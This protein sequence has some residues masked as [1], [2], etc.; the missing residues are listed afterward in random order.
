MNE[1]QVFLAV[2]GT[3]EVIR[4][5][6]I[7]GHA[8]YLVHIQTVRSYDGGGCVVKM[9]RI[10]PLHAGDG[11]GERIAGQ[12]AGSD[13]DRTFPGD[14]GDL[15]LM[16]GNE[17]MLPNRLVHRRGEA[18][19]VHRQRA[20]G[21]Y[22]VF[23]RRTH[24]ERIQHAHFGL[25]QPHGIGKAVAAQAVAAHQFGHGIQVL[26]RSFKARLHFVEIHGHTAPGDLPGGFTPGQSAANDLYAH[27]SSSSSGLGT[28][29]L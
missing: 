24:D 13:D 19:A 27:Q 4:A 17:R 16:N 11:L 7:A 9:E 29:V 8:K 20:A 18:H 25:E 14:V 3:V 28:D 5:A 6:I 23:I 26:G 21:G 15:L 10:Q 12:R 22:G 2:H 1:G